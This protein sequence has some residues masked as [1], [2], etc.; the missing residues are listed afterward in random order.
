MKKIDLTGQKIGRLLIIECLGTKDKHVVWRCKCDCGKEVIKTT[1]YIRRSPCPSCGCYKLEVRRTHPNHLIHGQSAKHNTTRIYRIWA[2]MKARCYT[3]SYTRF[4]N[5]GGRGI[6]VCDEWKNDFQAFYDW[7][8]SNG[9]QDNLTID[10]IDNDGDYHPNNCRWVSYKTQTRNSRTN[11][12]ITFNGETRCL[13]EWS[14]IVGIDRHTI[15]VRLNQL[16]WSI[17]R[18]LTQPVRR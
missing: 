5:W 3:P 14:E 17:E 13:N 9:Y 1:T 18:A 12:M 10:R 16:N 6:S 7:A 15:T 2:N 11:R 8:M 4:E